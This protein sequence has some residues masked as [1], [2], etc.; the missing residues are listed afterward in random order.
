MKQIGKALFVLT[1]S[2]LVV[3]LSVGVVVTYCLH[4]G[5]VAWGAHHTACDDEETTHCNPQERSCMVV[6]AEKL[7]P[8]QQ[9]DESLLTVPTVVVLLFAGLLPTLFLSLLPSRCVAWPRN[10]YHAPPAVESRQYLRLITVLQ[11]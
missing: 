10:L 1:L 5:N 4:S 7:S 2:A 6:I 9:A 8:S 3:S 11:I